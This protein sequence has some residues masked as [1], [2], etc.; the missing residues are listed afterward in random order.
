MEAASS[1]PEKMPP[2]KQGQNF[3]GGYGNESMGIHDLSLFSP[4]SLSLP[5]VLFTLSSCSTTLFF[6]LKK[7]KPENQLSLVS[8]Y[9]HNTTV[10]LA[11]CT[12]YLTSALSHG[13]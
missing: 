5:F 11:S 1:R 13:H 9:S 2:S 4:L 12:M 7:K 3:L 10:F 8:H 6:K